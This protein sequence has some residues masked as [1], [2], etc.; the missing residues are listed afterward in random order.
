M[1]FKRYI[2]WLRAGVL[3]KFAYSYLHVPV[4]QPVELEVFIVIAKGI[5]ELFCDLEQAHVKEELEH[6][7][8]W[9]VEVNVHRHPTAPHV[10]A[11]FQSVDLLPTNHGEDEEDISG[12]GH[13][14]QSN[15][16]LKAFDTFLAGCGRA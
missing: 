10:L 7:V 16:I 3:S 8:N 1:S 11:L 13:D 2:C 5:D 12:Q 9:N 6:G 4:D 15:Q 14:L